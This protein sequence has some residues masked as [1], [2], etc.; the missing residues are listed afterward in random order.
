MV[1]ELLLVALIA[2]LAAAIQGALGFGF[3]LLAAP[4]LALVDPQL[5]PGPVLVGLLTLTTM[6]TAR[7]RGA[8]DGTGVAWVLVGRVP[9]AAV[10]ALALA[11]LTQQALSITLAVVVLAA[12][13]LSVAGLQ[14]VPQRGTLLGAGVVSGVMEV[15]ASIG[16][17]PVA[18]VY[19]RAAAPVVR[20]T[21]SV[22]FMVGVTVSL[23]GVA[24]VGRFGATE[25]RWSLAL[26][27]GVVVGFV[28]SALLRPAVD[29]GLLAPAVLVLSAISAIAVLVQALW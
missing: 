8:V 1:G 21:L 12:V 17:P 16:G 4:L 29:R 25:L 22:I 18:L 7:E 5:V 24:S 3:S 10:G 27:P 14:L 6:M 20:G 23:I 28:A 2:A 15:A 26:I 13:A 19:R 9:G 11:L